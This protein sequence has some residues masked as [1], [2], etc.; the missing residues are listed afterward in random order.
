MLSVEGDVTRDPTDSTG[1]ETQHRLIIFGDSNSLPSRW[2]VKAALEVAHQK[3]VPVALLCDTGVP[4]RFGELAHDLQVWAAWKTWRIFEPDTAPRLPVQVPRFA[5]LSK[6]FGVPILRVPRSTVN[7]ARSLA[8]IRESGADWSLCFLSLAIF[9]P[10]LLALLGRPV[11]FHN[12]SLPQYRGLRAT[13]WSLY[14]GEQRSGY[15][16]HYMARSIDAGPVLLQDSLPVREGATPR[17]LDF[18]KAVR[19][20]ERL[21]EIFDLVMGGY[22]GESQAETPQYFNRAAFE[23]IIAV[24]RPS[25]LSSEEL[26]R[27]LRAFEELRLNL[28]GTVYPVTRLCRSRE[29]RSDPLDFDTSDGLR[30]RPCRFMHMPK[31]VYRLYQVLTGDRR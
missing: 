12:G 19:A 18:E 14:K 2:L 17:R 28:N 24:D 20:A 30:L 10:E 27:R 6:Q 3:S 5:R 22:A 31:A 8:R 21:P 25:E 16:F 23:K 15:A 11:N 4:R 9:G 1:R 29:K 26:F 7:E 13:C